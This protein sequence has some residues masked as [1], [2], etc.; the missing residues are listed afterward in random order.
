MP[1]ASEESLEALRAFL[2]ETAKWLPDAEYERAK[3]LLGD[4]DE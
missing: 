2:R 3:Q 4:L 1:P